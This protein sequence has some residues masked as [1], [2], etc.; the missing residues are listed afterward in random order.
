MASTTSLLAFPP[1]L[2]S[3]TFLPFATMTLLAALAIAAASL[4]ASL[5][6]AGMVSALS[7]P[8]ASR[9]LDALVQDVQ[10]LRW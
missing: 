9:N 2:N 1:G 5:R 4:R 6:L 3:L 7:I 10:P 8:C